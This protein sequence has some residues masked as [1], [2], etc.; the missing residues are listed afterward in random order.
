MFFRFGSAV[1]LAVAIS[2]VSIALEKRNMELRREISYQTFQTEVLVELHSKLR[3]QTQKAAAPMKLI[4][5]L[6]SGELE[7]RQI[8]VNEQ[9]AEDSLPLL[10]WQRSTPYFR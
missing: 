2:L 6:E 10:N 7:Q 4:D 9:A 3:S 5:S 8:K 1:I